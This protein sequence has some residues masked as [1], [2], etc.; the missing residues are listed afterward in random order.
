MLTAICWETIDKRIKRREPTAAEELAEKALGPLRT[1]L[2]AGFGGSA[3]RTSSS[4]RSSTRCSR[5]S[6]TLTGTNPAV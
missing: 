2:N 1:R 4:M 5:I 6:S 3:T